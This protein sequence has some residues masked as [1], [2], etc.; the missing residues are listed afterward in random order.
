MSRLSQSVKQAS[1]V[2]AGANFADD[3]PVSDLLELTHDRRRMDLSDLSPTEQASLI[4][5]RC[6]QLQPSPEALAKRVT[7]ASQ[8]GRPFV[9][10]LGI[11]PTGCSCSAA[12]SEW[13]TTLSSSSAM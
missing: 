9:A 8:R 6:E 10:K 11:D 13:A 3:A 2:L 1:E 4:A 12:S 5:E 7:E